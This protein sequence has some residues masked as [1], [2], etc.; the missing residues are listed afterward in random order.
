LGGE[1]ECH[2][3]QLK[4][5]PL[6]EE[7]WEENDFLGLTD[8]EAAATDTKKHLTPEDPAEMENA[9]EENLSQQLKVEQ[10]FYVERII[11]HQCRVKKLPIGNPFP[12]ERWYSSP[13]PVLIASEN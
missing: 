5:F 6:V 7:D 8:L 10:I 9:E 3:K 2:V 11:G 1:V 12:S 4:Q 13:S